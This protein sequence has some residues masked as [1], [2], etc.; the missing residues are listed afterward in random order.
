[1]GIRPPALPDLFQKVPFNSNLHNFEELDLTARKTLLKE[2]KEKRKWR[3]LN[4]KILE[5][6]FLDE[7]SKKESSMRTSLK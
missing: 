4:P 5:Q 3:R 6:Q 2:R 7:S 1:M